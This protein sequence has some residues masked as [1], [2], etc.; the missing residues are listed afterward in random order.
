MDFSTHI[1][2]WYHNEHRNLP[3]RATK[4]TYR[5]WLS[6]IILQQ[7]R[8]AQGLKYYINFTSTFPTIKDLALAN[9]EQVLKLWQGL[10]Y[11]SRARNLHTTAKH[12]YFNLNGEFPNN[13]QDIIKLKGIGP[14]TAAAISSIC[15][16]EKKAA[17]D[18][19]VY[20]VLSRAFN[21]N[22]PINSTLGKKEFQLLAD[23]L[24]SKKEPG[25]YN[26][27]LMELGA[28]VCTPK[29]ANCN[30]CPLNTICLAKSENTI[31]QLPVKDKKTKVRERHLNYFCIE[32]KNKLLMNKRVGNDI[33]KNLYDFP[34]QELNTACEEPIISNYKPIKEI[35]GKQSF[36]V[37]K[38]RKYNHK[39][40]HQ[41][42]NITVHLLSIKHELQKHEYASVTPK[43]ALKLPVPKPIEKFL[44]EIFEKDLLDKEL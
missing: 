35:L 42:L 17:V 25:N 33:W 19:N 7:T 8:V 16:N 30:S 31:Y 23:S 3:W 28:T 10:G 38:S 15:Y 9:E 20:R 4:E 11:Y 27:G 34:L 12:I 14:Y 18:G 24:I 39:L 41:N 1:L 43:E 40:S 13:Y 5:V 26:Q 36:T 32:H 6:E 22:T 21:I 29:K 2:Q 44:N 37:E